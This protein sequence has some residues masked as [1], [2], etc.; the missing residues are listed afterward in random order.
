MHEDPSA[1]R[2]SD[3]LAERLKRLIVPSEQPIVAPPELP[4][5]P[6]VALADRLAAGQAETLQGLHAVSARLEQLV[7]TSGE[8]RPPDPGPGRAL[9]AALADQLAA[10]QAETLYGLQTAASTVR[11]RAEQLER[12]ATQLPEDLGNRLWQAVEELATAASAQITGALNTASSR[13]GVVVEAL[14]QHLTEQQ[15]QYLSVLRESAEATGAQLSAELEEAAATVVESAGRAQASQTVV[16]AAAVTAVEALESSAEAVVQQVADLQ[17]QVSDSVDQ[18]LASISAAGEGFAE[19]AEGVIQT[20]TSVGEGFI[21]RMFEVLD[22]RDV[23]E[24]RLEE[25]LSARVEQISAD[26]ERRLAGAT[27][28][29]A[30]QVD[31]LELRDLTERSATAAELHDLLRRLLAEPRGKLRELRNATRSPDAAR[32]AAPPAPVR[33]EP[34]YQEAHESFTPEPPPRTAKVPAKKGPAKAVQRTSTPAVRKA[35]AKKAAAKRPAAKKATTHRLDRSSS[36]E[37]RP[38]RRTRHTTG[39]TN[40]DEDT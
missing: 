2:H 28:A 17:A 8:V 3:G 14:D 18:A 27:A 38:A 25:R 30:A 11:Q 24:Q 10:G 33:E 23:H 16:R 26:V 13:L 12:L 7:V 5:D 34:A 35:P 1:E 32:R 19:E 39:S 6:V 21:S 22:E 4:T 15:E 37:K 40:T 36:P 20:M 9:V 31:R 29:M